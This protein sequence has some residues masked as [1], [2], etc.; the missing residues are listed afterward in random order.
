MKN[1]KILCAF[2]FAMCV[3]ALLTA[4]PV[5]A[6][7]VSANPLIYPVSFSC[8]RIYQNEDGYFVN[9]EQANYAKI[10]ENEAFALELM[11]DE[12]ASTGEKARI[13]VTSE[14]YDFS[15]SQPVLLI[16]VDDTYY[17]CPIDNYEASEDTLTVVVTVGYLGV[18]DEMPVYLYFEGK[19][20]ADDNTIYARVEK[21]PN[22]EFDYGATI[23]V[24]EYYV[25]KQGGVMP[26]E[27]PIGMGNMDKDCTVYVIS[28]D[29]GQE[30]MRLVTKENDLIGIAKKEGPLVISLEY[31]FDQKCYV[32]AVT[33]K[34]MLEKDT[35]L[36]V[37]ET[38]GVSFT[39]SP[40][41]ERWIEEQ[42]TYSTVKGLRVWKDPEMNK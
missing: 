26:L 38:L 33:R 31:S 34:K 12:L 8:S 37:F 22:T 6:A 4:L 36:D 23:Q 30:I 42:E 10:G 14:Q 17:V 29:N 11:A 40:N 7:E 2:A 15:K 32:S 16:P 5:S 9:H 27:I 13:T 41:E 35:V 28:D 21:V 1:K 24:G 39:R 25:Q 20:L 3:M 18:N 19:R